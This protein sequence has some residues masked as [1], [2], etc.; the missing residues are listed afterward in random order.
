MELDKAAAGV[1]V[2]S[3]LGHM[4]LF[5]SLCPL[6]PSTSA[7]DGPTGDRGAA[8]TG[9]RN[10]AADGRTGIAR[11]R[12]S[13]MMMCPMQKGMSDRQQPRRRRARHA[14]CQSSAAKN[15]LFLQNTFLSK[16]I[17]GGPLGLKL[18]LMTLTP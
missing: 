13:C 8:V 18:P 17:Q 14:N 12:Y 1:E 4:F 16:A 5:L 2:R 7:T 10:T 9:R 6:P 15:L 11:P 3:I